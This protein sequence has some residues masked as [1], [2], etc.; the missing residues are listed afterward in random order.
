MPIITKQIDGNGNVYSVEDRGDGTMIQVKV[1]PILTYDPPDETIEFGET[2]HVALQLRDF[3][4]ELRS[5]NR[6]VTFIID[7]TPIEESLINGAVTLSIECQAYG[8]LSVGAAPVE[9]TMV[10]FS[11]QVV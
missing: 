7:G 2:L 10:P 8:S 6:S 3:D 1:D 5:D 9:L 11:V 4:G